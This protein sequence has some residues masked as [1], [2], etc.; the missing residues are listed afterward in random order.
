MPGG[1]STPSASSQA[2]PSPGMASAANVGVKTTDKTQSS[3][4]HIGELENVQAT[5]AEL[6]DCNKPGRT[7]RGI[8]SRAISPF[9]WVQT[10]CV[11]Y[12]GLS[13][14][15]EEDKKKL[16]KVMEKLDDDW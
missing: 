3:R 7:A 2:T 15:T 16:S 6:R 11:W 8:S 5:V 4:K 12:S 10:R 14:A 1:D 13:F 9:V